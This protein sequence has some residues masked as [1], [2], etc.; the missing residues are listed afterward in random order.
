MALCHYVLYRVLVFPAF[1][2]SAAIATT[3]KE[4]NATYNE[5][6]KHQADVISGLSKERPGW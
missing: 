4:M 6:T 3:L 1:R 2:I 5:L